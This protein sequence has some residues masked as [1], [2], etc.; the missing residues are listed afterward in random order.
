MYADWRTT[1]ARR[2]LWSSHNLRSQRRL[3]PQRPLHECLGNG[4]HRFVA[5]AHANDAGL[6]FCRRNLCERR[7]VD[8]LHTRA[9]ALLHC[10]RHALTCLWPSARPFSG[11]ASGQMLLVSSLWMTP[12][13]PSTRCATAWGRAE[14][15]RRRRHL[16]TRPCTLWR[17]RTRLCTSRPGP[18][19]HRG[20]APWR[21][22]LRGAAP[23]P[24]MVHVA[25]C[26]VL[27]RRIAAQMFHAACCILQN[28][29]ECAQS[30]T[31]DGTE[32]GP[33]ARHLH[34]SYGHSLLSS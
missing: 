25:S 26:M 6:A 5:A 12:T 16:L 29:S 19:R 17:H 3:K 9:H 33:T 8:M 31:K 10:C 32:A 24:A 2:C 18:T 22:T 11:K 27:Q 21:Q 30:R 7:L 20:T 1:E 15:T 28:D 23:K 13:R 14:S 34:C 4:T